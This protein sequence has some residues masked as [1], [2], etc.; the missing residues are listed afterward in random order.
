MKLESERGIDYTHLRDLLQAQKWQ[1][2]DHETLATMLKATGPE[3]EE[4]LYLRLDHEI[5]QFPCQDLCT[6]D[7]LWVNFSG[8]KFGFSVQR[9]LWVEVGG[10]L[11]FGADVA[12]AIAAYGHMS[13]RNGWRVNGRYITAANLTFDLSAPV[14][15]LPCQILWGRLWGWALLLSRLESCTMAD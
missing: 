8:G 6:I 2:A 10:Q 11:D 12:A 7:Q 1:Q 15:H 5:T 3:A 4:E 13:D 9:Q 14:G